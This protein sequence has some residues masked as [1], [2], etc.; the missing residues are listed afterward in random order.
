[1]EKL[2]VTLMEK[3]TKTIHSADF[4]IS[5][6]KS[7]HSF[8]RQRKMGFVEVIIFILSS[9]TKSL[10]IELEQFFEQNKKPDETMTKQ[11]FCAA[12][13]KILPA[14]FLFLFEQT[15]EL[16]LQSDPFERYGGYRLFAIDGSD[17]SLENSP[18]WSEK[19]AVKQNIK[20]KKCHARVS[21]VCDVIS[22]FLLDAKIGSLKMS[23]RMFAKEHL[24]VLK[25][26]LQKKDVFLFDRGYPS[27]ELLAQL[28]DE[29]IKYVMR[30][31][32]NF[33]A[34]IDGAKQ[35]DFFLTL[36]Y[37]KKKFK[38]R[39]VKIPLPT[40]EVEMLLTNVG[41]TG[42]RY[43][44]MQGVY[45]KRWAVESKYNDLKNKLLI[46]NFSGRTEE[47]LLQDFFATL[48]MAN[49]AAALKKDADEEIKE[50]DQK[51]N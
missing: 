50:V 22:G 42:F 10:Q 14:A 11:A 39:V 15:R 38:V 27:K 13:R 8:C 30:V 37:K 41:R 46:E 5:F 47:I 26:Y 12:R 51:K 43:A 36:S 24:A 3:I 20:D 31:S 45:Q 7:P 17:F 44:Q 21:L 25:P 33:Q 4:L 6:R 35:K 49:L 16:I 32:K 9:L 34:E 2:S 48:T 23:E 1:M 18:Q 29:K 28:N 19:F 40:G